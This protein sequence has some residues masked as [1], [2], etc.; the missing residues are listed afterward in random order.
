MDQLTLCGLTFGMYKS[1]FSVG[2]YKHF[3]LEI[4]IRKTAND[5]KINF[6]FQST[7]LTTSDSKLRRIQEARLTLATW[8]TPTSTP[9]FKFLNKGV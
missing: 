9:K 1:N 3:T 5:I 4:I 8:L 6:M 7:F 2:R